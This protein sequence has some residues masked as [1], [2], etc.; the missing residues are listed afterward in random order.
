[1]SGS[2]ALNTISGVSFAAFC[3]WAGFWSPWFPSWLAVIW[4]IAGVALLLRPSTQ[5][6]VVLS[7]VLL[8][9]PVCLRV[10]GFPASAEI[11]GLPSQG[12][13]VL[14]ALA[15]LRAGPLPLA[16]PAALLGLGLFEGLKQ[17][18]IE[19]VV[20]GAS[21]SGSLL[22]IYFG[23][24]AGLSRG[25]RAG[26]WVGLALVIGG[27]C[28]LGRMV[29]ERVSLPGASAAHVADVAERFGL[30]ARP[31]AARARF[32]SELGALTLALER[33]RRDPASDDL[34]SPIA[35][36]FGA[37]VPL[38][39]GWRPQGATLSVPLRQEVA[40]A[41]ERQGRRTEALRMLNQAPL[42]PELSYTYSLIARLDGEEERARLAWAR[43]IAPEDI[44]VFGSGLELDWALLTEGERSIEFVLTEP[45]AAMRFELRATAF[46]GWPELRV[47]ADE[48][49]EVTHGLTSAEETWIWK[50]PLD[51][52]P[53]RLRIDLVADAMGE[54]G[55]RNL[56]VDAVRPV[57]ES[58][59]ETELDG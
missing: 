15:V 58:D 30:D 24:A 53:H 59:I 7:V 6:V 29:A 46:E 43:A 27:C 18:A 37:E 32:R 28:G 54:G 3:V 1:M 39:V 33:L 34:A 10:I 38:R 23:V 8:V 45:L 36:A 25:G 48:R 9:A 4:C 41:L 44:P 11:A 20:A 40:W 35:L 42:T 14:L 49:F 50:R 55:D 21:P 19:P 56:W 13:A 26:R 17:W 47:V 2:D 12:A 31:L 5:H 16:L 52:G 22:W 51:V 57:V